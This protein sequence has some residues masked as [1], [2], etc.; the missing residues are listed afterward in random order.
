MDHLSSSRGRVT[1][2]DAGGRPLCRGVPA[3]L[4]R[5]DTPPPVPAAT[6][7]DGLSDP[8]RRT[9]SRLPEQPLPQPNMVTMHS[10]SPNASAARTPCKK[11]PLCRPLRRRRGV[12]DGPRW[13]T[14][15]HTPD[16]RRRSFRSPRSY[17][18]GRTAPPGGKKSDSIRVAW[19]GWYA[20]ARARASPRACAWAC[21][22]HRR[23]VPPWPGSCTDPQ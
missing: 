14:C 13:A 7:V 19:E 3:D 11:P 17:T 12:G 16:G 18:A 4:A 5:P 2:C 9:G 1:I 23:R 21:S 8:D 15:A 6:V 20:P 10:D 22:F